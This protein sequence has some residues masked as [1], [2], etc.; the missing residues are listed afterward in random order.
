MKIR[1]SILVFITFISLGYGQENYFAVDEIKKGEYLSFPIFSN[2]KDSLSAEKINQFLQISELQILKGKE[3]KDIFEN[4]CKHI[5]PFIE[6]N[7]NA[8]ID[9]SIIDNNKKNLTIYFNIS[10][11]NYPSV[12]FIKYYNFNSTNGDLIKLENLFTDDGFKNLKTLVNQK[13][14][15]KFKK[16]INKL[17]SIEKNSFTDI[18]PRLKENS[19]FDFT[20]NNDS[21]Y[22]D[23]ENF[24]NKF[25]KFSDIDMITNYGLSEFKDYLNDYG[26][27]LF[28]LSNDSI[29]KFR[30]K[31]FP[32]LFEG[33]IA[34][35]KILMILDKDEKNKI[36]AKYMYQKFGQ[37]IDIYGNING[38]KLTFTESD[39]KGNTRGL[40][41][42]QFDGENIIGTWSNKDKSKSYKF[43]VKRK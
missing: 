25:Q 3:K 23:N 40:I 41:E 39:N 28:S 36:S 38:S 22:I 4:L 19:F 30:S 37:V 5:E 2:P 17:D 16:E 24:L 1:L 26:K 9:F 42:A 18:I 27:A 33:T 14:V 7:G 13:S 6:E 10:L 32:Q 20:I 15:E 31:S 34:N 29:G 8:S 35:Q 12:S 43:I 11:C 21:I